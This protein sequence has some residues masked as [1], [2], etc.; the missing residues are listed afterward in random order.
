MRR[1]IVIC[2]S[3]QIGNVLMHVFNVL[4]LY[5]SIGEA[6]ARPRPSAPGARTEKLATVLVHAM[7][8]LLM[9]V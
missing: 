2:G 9:E 4:D 8:F 6:I 3:W 7:F 1:Q 5:P